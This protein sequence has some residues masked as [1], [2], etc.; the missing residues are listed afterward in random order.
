MDSNVKQ[1]MLSDEQNWE[2]YHFSGFISDTAILKGLI[3][4]TKHWNQIWTVYIYC[5]VTT[6][7]R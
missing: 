5:I 1:K 7:H 2:A 3:K 4:I 6:E